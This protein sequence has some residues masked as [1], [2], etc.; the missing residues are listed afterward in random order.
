MMNEELLIVQVEPPQKE[1]AGDYYYRTLAP[2]AAMAE[3]DGVYVVNFTNIHRLKD[4]IMET[5]DVLV[6]KNICD[7]DLLPLMRQRKEEGK[8]T[9][10]ELADDIRAV[11]PWNPVH[12]VYKDPQI[13]SLFLRLASYSDGMQFSVDELQRLYG[14]LNPNW[15]V[16]PNQISVIPPKGEFES[17]PGL[18]VGWGGS[19]GHLEDM[20]EIAGPLIDWILS[21][22]DVR[23]YLMCSE[24][25]W[26]LFYR[27]PQDRKKRFRTGSVDD[28]YSFLQELDVGLAPLRNTAFNRSRSDIKFLEYAI[29]GVTPVLQDLEPYRFVRNG[30]TGFLFKDPPGMM[31]ILETLKDDIEV[32]KRV[33]QSAWEYVLKARLQRDHAGERLE[34]Y[35]SRIGTLQGKRKEQHDKL[36][37]FQDLCNI[38][39]AV[40][41]GRHLR[42]M[43]TEFEDL[44]YDGMVISQ[45]G[46]D[47]LVPRT[48]FKKAS[49]LEANNYLPYLF[50]APCSE[51]PVASL[52]RAV[53]CNCRSLKSW[54]LMGEYHAQKKQITEAFRCFDKAAAIFPEYELSYLRVAALLSVIGLRREADQL[55]Q[56]AQTLESAC[57][58]PGGEPTS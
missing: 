23:L 56:K 50:G 42:L 41:N 38:E 16:F 45:E 10:Y 53:K 51:D 49:Q 52:E 35:R 28:Y 37:F 7:P 25:V 36:L 58:N 55:Y 19:H 11:P 12:F 15:A 2:G 30:D 31:R 14:Y 47:P 17:R 40:Q 54:I 44:L 4:M 1:D 27:L 13:I 24:P 6:L 48:L 43:P 5:A 22:D 9:V 8:L 33:S 32:R 34:F 26:D 29:H 20:A 39:G 46:K 3:E 21:T 18:V 57:R